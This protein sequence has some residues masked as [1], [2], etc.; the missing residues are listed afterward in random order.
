MNIGIKSTSAYFNAPKY[1][2]IKLQQLGEITRGLY[3]DWPK[4]LSTLSECL[5]GSIFVTWITELTEY[6]ENSKTVLVGLKR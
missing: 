4:C 5:L 2:L 3:G 6:L 1:L